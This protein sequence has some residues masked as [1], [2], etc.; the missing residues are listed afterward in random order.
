MTAGN[1]H[2]AVHHADCVQKNILA[3]SSLLAAAV[4]VDNSDITGLSF[5]DTSTNGRLEIIGV[6]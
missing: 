5:V 3:A 2:E 1:A 6:E 4:A